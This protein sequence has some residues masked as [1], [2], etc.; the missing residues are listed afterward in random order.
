MTNF[1]VNDWAVPKRFG[2]PG[3]P[4]KVSKT[5]IEELLLDNCVPWMPQDGDYVVVK[6]DKPPT[7]WNTSFL[8]KKYGSKDPYW[9]QVPKKRLE[10]FLNQLP[11]F[12]RT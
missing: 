6:P 8:V 11:T 3:T 9:K 7:G 10:P 5:H 2:P 12:I 1:K 4:F